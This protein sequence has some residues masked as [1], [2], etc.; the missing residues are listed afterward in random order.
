VWS[1]FGFDPIAAESAPPPT[2]IP[3]PDGLRA[4]LERLARDGGDRVPGP[5]GGGFLG[6]LA[7][8]LGV[9]GENQS[10]PADPW[11]TPRVVGG[12]YVDF[13]VVEHGSGRSWL[14]LG[15]DPGDGR[16]SLRERR[17]EL[18]EALR[19]PAQPSRVVA[20]GPL[21]RH[22]E[23]DLHRAR[24]ESLR[25]RIARGDLYQA[26]LAHRF[27][28]AMHGTPQDI[29]RVLRRHHPAPWSL[30]LTWGDAPRR[31]QGALLSASPELLLASDGRRLRTRPIKGTVARG[32]DARED[33]LRRAELCASDKDR[34]ELAMIVDLERNDLGRVARLGSVR[35]E[36]LG[37]VESYATVH[38]MVAQVRANLAPGRDSVDALAAL[39]PGGSISGAPKLRAMEIIA[40]LEGEGRGFFTGSAGFLDLEDRCAFN[41]LIRSLVWRPDPIAAGPAQQTAGEVSFHVGGGITW[42][43]DAA[44]EEQETLDKGAALAAA[45]ETGSAQPDEAPNSAQPSLARGIGV[46]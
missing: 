31:P 11:R 9:P 29:Q 44:R 2:G 5:F 13:V 24:I 37:A 8:D 25:A 28:R 41:V 33:E 3:G 17:E 34:A 20:A 21:V 23:G 7:Y 40:E 6:A 4:C 15:E 18:L 22:I 36:E 14:V 46:P 27:T 38:H 10:L 43:S 42:S 32:V 39:F 26:N 35:V 19:A 1:L 45:L 12:L 16:P 30:F